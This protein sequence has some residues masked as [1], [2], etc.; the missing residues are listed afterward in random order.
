M[1][2]AMQTA[3]V[4]PSE[5]ARAEVELRRMKGALAGWLRYRSINDEVAAGRRPARLPPQAAAV[6]VRTGRDAAAERRMALRL[7]ALLSEAMDAQ[8]LPDP[9][10]DGDAVALARIAVAGAVPSEAAAPQAQGFIWLWPVAIVVGAV[11]F[12]LVA[13]IHSDADVLKERE[14]L[15]CIKVGACTDYGFWL[16]LGG[17]AL[18]SYLAWEKFGLKEAV[19]GWRRR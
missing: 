3:A 5:R 2:S 15:E 12:T 7:H 13:K 10:K 1:P 6:Y 14:R 17:I 18:V 19:A 8:Q 16:K 4:T 9:D 11:L